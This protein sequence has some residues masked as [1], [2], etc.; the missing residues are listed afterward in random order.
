MYLG[1]P[2]EGASETNSKF[3]EPILLTAAFKLQPI[4]KKLVHATSFLETVCKKLGACNK[5]VADRFQKFANATSFFCV[6]QVCDKFA[7]SLRQVCDNILGM[8]CKQLETA[9]TF[10]ERS[11]THLKLHHH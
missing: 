5:F 6:F 4:C 7:T 9:S 10:W 8:V 3:D 11:A 2:D 1:Q